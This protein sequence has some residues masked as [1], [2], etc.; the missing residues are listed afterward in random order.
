M[1]KPH[2]F[3]KAWLDSFRVQKQYS[4]INPPLLEKMVHAFSLLQYLQTQGLSFIFKGGTSL[5]LLLENSNRFSVDID[6]LTEA[7]RESVE[8]ILDQ[9]V[10]ASHFKGWKLDEKRSYGDGVPKAHYEFEYESNVN[11]RSNY[12][13]LDILYEKA[14]YP[15]IQKRAIKSIWIET[16]TLIEIDLPTIEAITG[17]K[18]TAFAPTTTGIL[19]GKGKELEIIKQL[20]DLGNLF[21]QIENLEEVFASFQAFAEQEIAYRNLTINALDVL[22]DTI[23]TC[24]I[25]AF[26]D[27]NR[28]E[29][30]RSR[31]TELQTGIRSFESYLISGNFRIDEAVTAAAK[32][33]YL[34]AKLLI[35]DFTPVKKY[36]GQD[37]A[38]LNIENQNWNGLNRLKRFPDQST[39]FYWYECLVT[40]KQLTNE[41]PR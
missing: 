9:V 17:D 29:P 34:C 1:I 23:D 25:I 18:L 41:T 35:K 12:I 21:D 20:F 7:S 39:Y 22:N 4:R 8:K 38:G 2:C 10:E 40:L 36:S 15:K 3:E 37:I 13:L 33:A 11:K 26:R 30:Q 28:S 5:I 6:I 31:F 27:R 32:I 19:Y 14:H 16:E 24:R